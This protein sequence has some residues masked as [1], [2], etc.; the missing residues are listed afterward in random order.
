MSL[1]D[2]LTK[3]KLY[4]NF[5][6]FGSKQKWKYL[7]AKRTRGKYKFVDRKK[8][9]NKLCIILA[10][11]KE[12]LYEDVFSRI[13]KF[14]SDDIDVCLVSSG[15]Y[16]EKLDKI[17]EE[18]NWSYVSTKKNK[19]TLDKLPALGIKNKQVYFVLP[20]FLCNFG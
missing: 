1:Y 13:K 12:F 5:I 4:S 11:Y 7:R 19:V 14:I 9:H 18:N 17:A 15:L 6:S 10:G 8:D 3:T 2:K 16:S 20:S